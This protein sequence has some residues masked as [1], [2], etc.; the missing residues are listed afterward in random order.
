MAQYCDRLWLKY[1]V[2][3]VYIPTEGDIE[4]KERLMN[5]LDRV[6]DTVGD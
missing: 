1:V 6:V 2:V 3:V 5:D 4:V